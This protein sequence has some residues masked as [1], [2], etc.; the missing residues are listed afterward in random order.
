[1][2]NRNLYLGL[3]LAALL[4][5]PPA[6]R[7]DDTRIRSIG[8]EVDEDD[9]KD[10]WISMDVRVTVTTGNGWIQKSFSPSCSFS[11]SDSF[12]EDGI[13]CDISSGMCS[14][15]SSSGSMEVSCTDRGGSSG[16]DSEGCDCPED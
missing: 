6:L 3:P 14:G 5:A 12:E 11:F 13:E 1:M 7:A 8:I 2:R 15:F 16:S 10:G 4:L 9:C